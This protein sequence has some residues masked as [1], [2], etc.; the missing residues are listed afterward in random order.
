VT[1]A[2]PWYFALNNRPA[3]AIATKDGGMDVLALNVHTGDFERDWDIYSAYLE[4]GRDVDDLTKSEF[5]ALVEWHRARV[6]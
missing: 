2:L 5:D 3:M 6:K 4:G 1:K